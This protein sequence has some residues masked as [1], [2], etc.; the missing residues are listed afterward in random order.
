MDGVPDLAVSVGSRAGGLRLYSG[1]KLKQIRKTKAPSPDRWFGAAVGAAGDVDGD[2]LSDIAIS[3]T[4]GFG[5]VCVISSA[6][7]GPLALH[8]GAEDEYLGLDTAVGVGDLTGDGVPELA[9]SG[10]G[11]VRIYR[12]ASSVM[13]PIARSYPLVRPVAA[14]AGSGTVQVRVRG[15]SATVTIGVKG[16][17]E[18]EL[19]VAL[20]RWPGADVFRHVGTLL[21]TRPDKGTGTLVLSGTDGPPE[22][23]GVASLAGLSGRR[24]RLEAPDSSTVLSVLLPPLAPLPSVHWSLPLVPPPGGPIPGAR[25]TLRASFDGPTFQGTVDVRTTGLSAD[26]SYALFVEDAP[27]SGTFL[28]AGPLDSGRYLRSTRTGAPLPAG[29]L[30]VTELRGRRVE[31]RDAGSGLVVLAATIP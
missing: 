12:G 18:S 27:G 30:T 23:L 19:L 8:E 11:F 21:V 7:R 15:R 17:G 28:D 20:E 16:V 26:A 3:G 24:V 5:F 2:G 29:V 22:A 31:V 13:A 14:G 1:R 10:N 9:V 6:G 25:G 4:G